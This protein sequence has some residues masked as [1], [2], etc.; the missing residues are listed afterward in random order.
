MIVSRCSTLQRMQETLVDVAKVRLPNST[1][2]HRTLD[3]AR[4]ASACARSEARHMPFVGLACD[5]QAGGFVE[6]EAIWG[7]STSQQDAAADR[8]PKRRRRLS[9]KDVGR[10]A[11]DRRDMR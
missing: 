8:R 11:A 1:T 5:L 2:R 9:V 3:L 7:M 10:T 4:I 6:R